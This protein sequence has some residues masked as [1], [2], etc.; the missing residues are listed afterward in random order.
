MIST[1]PRG[2]IALIS[3][4]VIST[5]LL[6][7]AAS[8]GQGTFFSRFD[9][10]NGEYKTISRGFAEACT[11]VALL[12]IADQYSYAVQDDSDYDTER[13]GV[14]V[15]LGATYGTGSDCLIAAPTTTPAEVNQTRTYTISTQGMFKGAYTNLV[16]RMRVANPNATPTLPG[17]DP[18]TLLSTEE[19]P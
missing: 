18:V 15:P 1:Q 10:L 19:I 8:L 17:S 5:I 11:N 9:A 14:V 3:S 6:S 12:R 4:I 13:S 16:T 2:F 7:L